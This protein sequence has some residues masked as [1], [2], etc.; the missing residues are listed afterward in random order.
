MGKIRTYLLKF[1]RIWWILNDAQRKHVSD[2]FHK[3]ALGALLPVLIKLVSDEKS[4]D[5]LQIGILLVCAIIC[6]II[7]LWSLKTKGTE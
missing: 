7:A 1:G 2:V 4:G 5:G 6:E 3:L